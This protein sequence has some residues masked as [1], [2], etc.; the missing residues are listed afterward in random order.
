MII[1]AFILERASELIELAWG[2]VSDDLLYF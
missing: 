2:D 1:I